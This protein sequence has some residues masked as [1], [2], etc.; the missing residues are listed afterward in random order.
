MS[1]LL[2][3]LRKDLLLRLADRTALAMWL[4]IPLVLGG[5]MSLAFNG[6]AG[7]SPKAQVWLVDQDD[8]ALSQILVGALDSPSMPLSVELVELEVGEARIEDGQGSALIVVPAGFAKALLQETPTTLSVVTNPSQTILP[9]IVTDLTDTLGE[10]HFYLHR[11][12]GGPLKKMAAGPADQQSFF[13][14]PELIALSLQVN[15][16]VK[17]LQDLLFPPLIELA[18]APLPA[19]QKQPFSFGTMMLPGIILMSLMFIAQGL[20]DELWAERDGGTWARLLASPIGVGPLLF[21]KLLSGALTMGLVAGLGLLAGLLLFDLPLGLLP[22]AFL[23]SLAVAPALLSMFFLF[24]TLGST[25]RASSLLSNVFL[26]PLIMAGGSFFPFEAMPDFLANIGR[27]T[28][29]GRA[30]AGLG[31]I[32]SGELGLVDL[33]VPL[34]A[35]VAVGALC[36]S[37]ALA[38]VRGRFA[39]S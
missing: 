38:R 15:E 39:T 23:W 19:G 28:P 18:E 32:L 6:G 3:A 9:H 29:N 37:L 26:F 22:L 17:G 12:V 2:H 31:G 5:L 13:P 24:G 16:A 25:R 33:L 4:G 20:A 21:S 27:M 30:V 35:L 8:S 14:D 36:Y 1:F 10:V 34:A 7:P 11:I